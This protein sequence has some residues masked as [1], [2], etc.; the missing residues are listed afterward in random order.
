MQL[1]SRRIKKYIFAV[2]RKLLSCPGKCHN[3]VRIYIET[4]T[5]VQANANTMFYI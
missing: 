1:H 5:L 4:K 2:L 3:Y